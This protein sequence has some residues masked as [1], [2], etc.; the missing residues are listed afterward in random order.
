MSTRT[1]QSRRIE[2]DLYG[3]FEENLDLD[4]LSDEELE[5]LLFEED[6]SKQRGPFNLPTMAG[7]S[8]IVV[9]IAYLL[10]RLGVLSGFNL[11]AMVSWLPWLAGV[12][13]IL[14]GFG[15]LSW[16]PNKKKRSTVSKRRSQARTRVREE[17]IVETPSRA[18]AKSSSKTTTTTARTSAREKSR[19]RLRKSSDRK[20]AGVCG[21]LA[22]YFNLDPTLVRIAFVL[23]T[24]LTPGIGPVAPIA[25]LI[26]AFVM[27]PPE[28][29][30]S[31]T[32]TTKPRSDSSEEE[33]ITIIKDR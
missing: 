31:A 10:E 21:G 2:E 26:L 24:I 17:V 18:S 9:G 3:D 19:G 12:L 29:N 32:K 4:T 11:G 23:G 33:R 7:L 20:I 13:I 14:L 16:R 28:K 5:E 22:E 1:R 15:V 27:S 25:Y 30:A 6:Q 8:M